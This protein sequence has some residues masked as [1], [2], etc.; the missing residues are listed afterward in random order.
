MKIALCGYKGKM[1]SAVYEV[2][3]KEYEI[4]PVEK[5]EITLD[6]IIS[7]VDLVLDFTVK[8]VA[9]DHIRLC[10]QYHKNFISGTT[11]FSEAELQQIRIRCQQ[12]KVHGIICY[13]F[14]TP[15]NF[16]LEHM[17][18]WKNYFQE[19]EYLDI[20]HVSKKD[21]QSGTTQLFLK[22]N[23]KLVVKSYQ[24]KKNTI[25]YLIQMK[26]KYDKITITYHVLDRKAFAMG[27]YQVL[28]KNSEEGI[29]N[30]LC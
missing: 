6:K 16:M 1:G 10:L 28:K 23:G 2:L 5:D 30:L 13:N 9:I 21:K 18:E 14:A 15:I 26:T 4:F 7:Q 29:I 24:T 25:T 22:K 17:D 20:H 27:V 3:K 8:E 19:F 11:G 12:E